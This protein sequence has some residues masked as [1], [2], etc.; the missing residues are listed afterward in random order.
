MFSKDNKQ[1]NYRVKNSIIT[2]LSDK[3]VSDNEDEDRPFAVQRRLQGYNTAIAIFVIFGLVSW[4]FTKSIFSVGLGL[5]LAAV[6]GLLSY[7][8]RKNISAAGYDVWQMEVLEETRLTRLNRRPTGIYAEALNGPY[9]GKV[10]HLALSSQGPVPP[11]GR[12]I[13]VTVPGDMQANLI[14][15][16]YYIPNYYGIGLTRE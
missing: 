16:V 1:K 9:Q 5:L 15:D 10:C 14:R 7:L 4:V 11:V 13:E 2:R 3:T 6:I 12:I 8:Q